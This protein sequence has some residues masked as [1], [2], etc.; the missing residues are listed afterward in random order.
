[1]LAPSGYVAE[2]NEGCDR[3]GTCVDA[4]H[5]NAIRLDEESERAVVDSGKCMGCGLCKDAC[6]S[7]WIQ[8]RRD[9]SKGEPLDLGVLVE[10]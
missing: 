1:M 4:C 9:P 8:L 2:V 6:P 10:G 7:E 5:F 3:C